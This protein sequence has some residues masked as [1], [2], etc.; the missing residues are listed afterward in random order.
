VEIV[1]GVPVRDKSPRDLVA[2][3]RRR[4]SALGSFLGAMV[5]DLS[6][7]NRKQGGD[8]NVSGVLVE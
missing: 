2:D 6:R 7:Q 3:E 1:E 4:T 5:S 8:G